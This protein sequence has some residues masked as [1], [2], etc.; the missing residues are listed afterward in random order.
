MPAATSSSTETQTARTSEHAGMGAVPYEG[1]VAFRV[2]APNADA[3]A[4]MGSF[5]D[6][7]RDASP[8]ASEGNGYWS[9][10]V[11]EARPGDE[12]K[13][14]LTNGDKEL[15]RADPY[16]RQMTNSVGNAV[17]YDGSAFD[18][19]GD[20][21]ETEAWNR[22]VIYELHIGTFNA[23]GEG[24][25]TFESAIERLDDV[26]D[27]GANALSVMPVGEFAGDYSWG[28]NGAYPFAVESVYGGPDALKRFIKEAHA[29][30]LA[31]L[32]D[33]VYNHL[34]P[35]DL[36][37]WQFDGWSE[38]GR[39]GIYFYNDDRAKTPWGDTRPDYGRE[40]VRRYFRDNA[41]MWLEDFHADGLRWDGTIFIRNVDFTGSPEGDL[42][43]GWEMM[44]EINR[45]IHER[46]PGK[47]SI[48]EDLQKNDHITKEVDEGGAG[49]DAQWDAAF[50]HPIRAALVAAD[51]E[52][53]YLD[54]VADAVRHRYNLDAFERVVYT[55]SH[56]EVANGQ[57]R[58]P[59][60]IDADDA[61]GWAAQKR[62]ALGAA[63][64]FTAPGIPML[65]QGQEVL[66]D[67]WFRDTEPVD[68]SRMERHG[69]F[70]Q[71]FRDL[72]RLRRDFDGA[73][74]GLTGQHTDVFHVNH[75][76]KVLAFRRWADG[77]PGDETVVVVNLRNTSYGAYR[78]GLPAAG[79]W[80]VRFNSDWQGYSEAFGNFEAYD[81]EASEDGQDGLPASG[82]VGLGPY[83]A[84][85]LSQDR[86]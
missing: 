25:G 36:D 5:N 49:F 61:E 66:T 76:A 11:A 26:R 75:E 79:R 12:Y 45:E 63:L 68:W 77:G 62:A 52:A 3:V 24:P 86:P 9:A 70:R 42:P 48:A 85:V 22:L 13:F 2:W 47:L 41:M 81:A 56:D 30:G 14:A 78:I 46:M 18:W 69:G 80:R 44:R 29:R 38:S 58:V 67:G 64:V 15:V 31:V 7:S 6:W 10:D 16:A 27:L 51:D 57:A 4:V 40:E 82:E 54:A 60:E 74:R 23:T 39:G 71:L 35:S 73:T 8:L 1:G 20:A 55:E 34:G 72:I 50:V 32:L 65:F 59:E 53:R 17:V 43:E 84:L 28:Y 19:E 83:T 37:L 21:F 33:V